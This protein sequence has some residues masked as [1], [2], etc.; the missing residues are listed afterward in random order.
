[1]KLCNAGA[2]ALVVWYLLVPPDLGELKPMSAWQRFASYN[3]AKE[4]D[5]ARSQLAINAVKDENKTRCWQS[6]SCFPDYARE[7]AQCI[8]TDDPRLKEHD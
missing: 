2:L 8:A 7:N 1:M 6:E 5:S 3:T 4:C